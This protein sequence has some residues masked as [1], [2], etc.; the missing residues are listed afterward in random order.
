MGQYK[1]LLGDS[2]TRVVIHERES[3]RDLECSFEFM[4]KAGDS[5]HTPSSSKAFS[6]FKNNHDAWFKFLR[7]TSHKAYDS[8]FTNFVHHAGKMVNHIFNEFG[9][10]T[11]EIK[12]NDFI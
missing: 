6:T 9:L 2:E 1:E 4:K 7:K 3:V 11:G 8:S 12:E 5:H 10:K